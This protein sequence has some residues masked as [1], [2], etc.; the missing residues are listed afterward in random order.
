[1]WVLKSAYGYDRSDIAD[2]LESILLKKEFVIEDRGAFW[3]ALARYRR[4]PADFSDYLVGGTSTAFDCPLTLTF[5][6]C[7]ASRTSSCSDLVPFSCE[8]SAGSG[9]SSTEA[10]HDAADQLAYGLIVCWVARTALFD[11]QA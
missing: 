9:R 2:V 7:S 3:R 5:D 11:E 8:V 10:F 4:Y 6:R 1:V